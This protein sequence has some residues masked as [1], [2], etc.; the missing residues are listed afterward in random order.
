[1]TGVSYGGI[2][3]LNLARLRNRI[4]LPDGSFRPWRSPN[5]TP[6]KIAA[7]YARWP[8]S[9]LTYALQPNG[10]FLDF[11][12]PKPNQSDHARRRDE[13]ELQRRA[14]LQRQR[15]RL[16]RPHGWRVQLRHH[17]LEGAR[18]PRRARPRR[19]PRRGQGAHRLP[20][21]GGAHGPERG[22]ARAERLDGRS[23]PSHRG[24]ARVPHLPRGARRAHLAAARRPRPSARLER[25]GPRTAP[26]SARRQLLRGVP[27][28]SGQGARQ[29][30]RHRR[31]TDVPASRAGRRA[32]RVGELGA[33]A[34]EDRDHAAPPAAADELARR[35]PGHRPGDRPDRAAAARRAGRS[36]PNAPR[37]RP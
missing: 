19:R 8:G 27:E 33:T 36:R 32:L 18:R 14:L 2:Q 23:L 11:R 29:R 6:L 22:T 21:L 34:P 20:Q 3:S 5:G 30:Q 7:A 25:P 31:H 4:R 26:W 35:Q 16:L 1:M 28:G 37:E 12:T 10:R 13:E 9:D 15:E 24:A 17:R